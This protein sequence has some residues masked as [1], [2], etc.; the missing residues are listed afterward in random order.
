LPR[1]RKPRKPRETPSPSTTLAAGRRALREIIETCAKVER[2]RLNPFLVDVKHSVEV[3]DTYLPIWRDIPDYLLDGQAVQGLSRVVIAQADYFAYITEALFA[4]PEVVERRLHYLPKDALARILLRVWQPLIAFDHLTIDILEQAYTYFKHLRPFKERVRRLSLRRGEEEFFSLE[5]LRRLGIL[6]TKS[7]DEMKRE[8]LE[9]LRR[10]A[11]DRDLI[12][13]RKFLSVGD[14][15]EAVR[16]AYFVSILA[17]E[18]WIRVFNHQGELVIQ[19]LE[20]PQ[21]PVGARSLVLPIR[22]YWSV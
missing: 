17:S 20:K 4:T 16:R 6:P 12:P 2:G 10:L 7:I 18:G 8:V 1:A 3:L 15:R 11:A 19:V 14:Y 21:P 9:E 22:Q 5:T 13:Y